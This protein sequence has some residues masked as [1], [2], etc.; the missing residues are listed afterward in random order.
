MEV[1]DLFITPI[2][3]LFVLGV[4][5]VLKPLV[6]T[7]DTERYFLPALVVKM[8]GAI[9]LGAIYQFYYGGGDT[10][11]Y[12]YHG[13]FHIWQAFLDDPMKGIKL[14]LAVSLLTVALNYIIQYF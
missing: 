7:P 11:N 6:T 12:F 4:A 3:I 10:F 9:A 14:I 8:V 2:V 5:K 1:K 13:T